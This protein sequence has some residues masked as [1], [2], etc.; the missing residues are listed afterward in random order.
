MG[1]IEDII[2]DEVKKSMDS[3]M[4]EQIIREKVQDAIKKSIEDVFCWSSNDTR[5]AIDAKL[6]EALVPAIEKWN[7]ER[8]IPKLDTVLTDICNQTALA[9][10]KRILE[11]FR[12]LMIEPDGTTI[13][14]SNIFK[15]YKK[16]VAANISTYGR[17]VITEEE[18]RYESVNVK[19]EVE[20]DESLRYSS[21]ECLVI[22]LSIEDEHDE[23]EEELNKDICI[24]R[25]KS[26]R[27]EGYE[28]SYG[29]APEVKGL[30]YMDSF[31]IFLLRLVRANINILIDVED[32]E[33]WVTPD[34]V[35]EA[36]FS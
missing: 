27:I 25:Y 3:G 36:S 10:N 26:S 7:F 5:K 13:N 28:I 24:W 4:V 31:E 9:D 18:P 8:F 21:R 12:E 22:H 20:K 16:F 6:N 23:D 19:L 2:V 30:K 1:A 17:E 32:D 29:V 14:L 35:P 11:H 15:E 33:D 34:E